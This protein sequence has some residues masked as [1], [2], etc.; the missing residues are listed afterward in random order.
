MVREAPQAPLVIP[1]ERSSFV[2]RG[3]PIRS[4]PKISDFRRQRGPPAGRGLSKSLR[5][6]KHK[7][8]ESLRTTPAP[9]IDLLPRLKA[10]ESDH[11]IRAV[12]A[13][14]FQPALGGNRRHTGG[15][16]VCLPRRAVA[17]PMRPHRNPC[18][19][20]GNHRRFTAPCGSGPA[21]H[22]FRSTRVNGGHGLQSA[23]TNGP[24]VARPPP[25]DG[26]MRSY[27]YHE[28]QNQGPFPRTP[29]RGE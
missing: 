6:G 3:S 25:E 2:D 24:A 16:L 1:E 14:R 28:Q 7:L 9:S 17:R 12:E 18:H 15:T 22:R 5:R 26:G 21:S 23:G 19:R 20:R 8:T 13:L 11:R 10:R 29:S 4:L 27:L